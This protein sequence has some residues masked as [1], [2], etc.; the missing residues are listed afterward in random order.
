MTKKRTFFIKER[1]A[2]DIFR[3]FAKKKG[4]AH[5]ARASSICAAPGSLH[6]LLALA[7]QVP[8]QPQAEQAEKDKQKTKG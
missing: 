3:I 2:I 6:G 1:R 4:K 5:R 8:T 7:M